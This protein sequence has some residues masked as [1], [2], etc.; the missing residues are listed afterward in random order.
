ML[1]NKSFIAKCMVTRSVLLNDVYSHL[2]YVC[3]SSVLNPV[4]HVFHFYR[5]DFCRSSY[6]KSQWSCEL[7]FNALCVMP[8][9][10]RYTHDTSFL[11]P[12][13]SI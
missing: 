7:V 8:I 6:F 11:L 4:I 5:L 3:N 9:K 1:H 13:R 12:C 10:E 2:M